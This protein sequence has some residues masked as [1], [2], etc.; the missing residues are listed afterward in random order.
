MQIGH[1]LL[2]INALQCIHFSWMQVNLNCFN[3]LI[4]NLFQRTCERE[5]RSNNCHQIMIARYMLKYVYEC[6]YYLLILQVNTEYPVSSM[7]GK[8]DTK[9]V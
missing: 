3:N 5:C 7:S 8:G 1:I 4:G 9:I 6:N 2:L